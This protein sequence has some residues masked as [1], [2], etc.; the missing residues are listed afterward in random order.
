VKTLR[1]LAERISSKAPNALAILGMK[2]VESGKVFLLIAKGQKVP[3]SVKAVELIKTLAPMID[4]KGGGKPDM[5]QA[6]GT[7]L[8]GLDQVFK[9]AKTAL[10]QVLG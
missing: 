7:K 5:A 8:D 2:Q 9:S 6:G 3:N 10:L 4:G 1:E